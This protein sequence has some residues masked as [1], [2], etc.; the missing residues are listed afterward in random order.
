MGFSEDALRMASDFVSDSFRIPTF[1][2]REKE[3]AR[4]LPF[5]LIRPGFGLRVGSL[6][7]SVLFEFGC[8]VSVLGFWSARLRTF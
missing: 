4:P 7:F 6:Q 5:I 8:L 1:T 3:R 2:W